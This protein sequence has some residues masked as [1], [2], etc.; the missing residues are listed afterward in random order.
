M[1]TR[2]CDIS[3]LNYWRTPPIVRLLAAGQE[4]DWTLSQI[5]SRDELAAFR[6]ELYETL[7]F[8]R[9]FTTSPH[10]RNVGEQAKALRDIFLFL[11]PS[12]DGPVDLLACQRNDMR[13]S[14][15][16]TPRLWSSEGIGHFAPITDDVSVAS[17]AFALQQIAARA[18]RT[19]TL[20]IASEL[21]GSFAIYDAP[22]PIRLMLQKLADRNRLPV[23]GGWEPCLNKGR[24]TNLWTREPL[25]SPEELAVQAEKSKGARGATKLSE[26]AVLVKPN[27]AS[28]LEVQTGLLLGLSRRMGG[29][30]FC[31]FEFNKK[32]NFTHEARIISQRSHC[33]CDLYWEE[34]GLDLECQ[35]NMIHGNSRSYISDFDRATALSQMGID[36]LF[37]SSAVLGNPQRFDALA[38][39]IGRKLG[40]ERR[41]KTPKQIEA[42][43][44]LRQELFIDWKNLLDV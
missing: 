7:P 19:R 26:T 36:V 10:W 14:S 18:S 27:A 41:P 15:L 32:L 30:G 23:R 29:E 13:R 34:A 38:Q 21:C 8:C 22:P 9:L 16:A 2:I 25:L 28:P 24:I 4:D 37:A 44:R 5:L 3:A 12:F 33:Y 43:R 1:E 17:P 20:M 39:T 35:S 40:C 6:A 42:N 31:G 11:A